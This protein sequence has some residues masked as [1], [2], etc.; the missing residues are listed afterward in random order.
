MGIKTIGVTGNDGGEM[1]SL[2]NVLINVPAFRTDRIQEMH[3][4][5]GHIICE[6]IEKELC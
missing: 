6:V 1:K 2:C 4:A 5:I 3:I